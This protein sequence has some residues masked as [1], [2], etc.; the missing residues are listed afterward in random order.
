MEEKLKTLVELLD[1]LQDRTGFLPGEASEENDEVLD[2]VLELADELLITDKGQPNYS[3]FPIL[4]KYGYRVFAGERD[5]FGWLTG[6]I[7]KG[8]GPVVV[9]G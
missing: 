9:F 7:Q 8:N 2:Q 1:Q 5:G 3:V 4:N 6:C